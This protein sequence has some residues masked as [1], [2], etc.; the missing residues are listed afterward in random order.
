M[1]YLEKISSSKMDD[2]VNSL[3]RQAE[4][5]AKYMDRPHVVDGLRAIM[6]GD[7][8]ALHLI[9]DDSMMRFEPPWET[10]PA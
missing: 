10:I 8:A 2:A 1:S 9:S 6:E 7:K 5:L 4:G 3:L